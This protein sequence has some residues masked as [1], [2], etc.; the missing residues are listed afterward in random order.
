MQNLK[1]R[2]AELSPAPVHYLGVEGGNVEL[3]LDPHLLQTPLVIA[4]KLG[5][6]HL[7]EQVEIAGSQSAIPALWPPAGD[8]GHARRIQSL[9]F[10]DPPQEGHPVQEL[11]TN[12]AKP[13]AGEHGTSRPDDATQPHP[14]LGGRYLCERACQE[15]SR[16]MGGPARSFCHDRRASGIRCFASVQSSIE[17][18][19]SVSDVG[20]TN[21]WQPEP[22]RFRGT[23]SLSLQDARRIGANLFT[24]IQAPPRDDSLIH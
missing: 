9:I 18:M 5:R 4:P 1:L 19:V 13:R 17:S 15:R 23:M 10:D 20:Q 7:I 12:L 11:E 14:H 22:P 24:I 16:Q 2:F 3:F 21:G 8:D 6:G